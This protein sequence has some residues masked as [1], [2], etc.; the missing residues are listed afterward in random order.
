MHYANGDWMHKTNSEISSIVDVNILTLK[1]SLKS[2]PTAMSLLKSVD[3]F[4]ETVNYTRGLIYPKPGSSSPQPLDKV[5]RMDEPL[6]AVSD[7]A[8]LFEA[9]TTKIGIAFKPP[10][11]TD[12]AIKCVKDA[13]ELVPLLTAVYM[14]TTDEQD[15]TLIRSELRI[16][17]AELLSAANA[18]GGELSASIK[19]PFSSSSSSGQL[20]SIGQVW[21]CC[22]NLQI[23]HTLGPQGILKEKVE[24]FSSLLKDVKEDLKSWVEEDGDDLD[25]DLSDGD[26]PDAYGDRVASRDKDI[27]ELGKAWID[28]IT[29][30]DILYQAIQK[31]RISLLDKEESTKLYVIMGDISTALDDLVASFLENF[32]KNELEP[33]AQ[34]VDRLVKKLLDLVK[35]N[36]PDDKFS[37]WSLMFTQNFFKS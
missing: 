30:L 6:K 8:A 27:E 21:E 14:G 20:V 24:E 7:I 9:H 36:E 4:T 16:K 12:A 5:H 29:K 18:L 17:V 22:K 32:Q 3:N 35:H 19:S 33:L 10:I 2:S 37:A 34:I 1:L 23:L 13:T 28:K 26:E 15:G 25:W 11:S 31:R